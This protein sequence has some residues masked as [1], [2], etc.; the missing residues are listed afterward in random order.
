MNKLNTNKRQR[1]IGGTILE[2]KIYTSKLIIYQNPISFNF[3][4]VA[5]LSCDRNDCHISPT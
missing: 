1:S 4:Y 2:K 3:K 5:W